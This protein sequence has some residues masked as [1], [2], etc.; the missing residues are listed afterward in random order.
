MAGGGVKGG[1]RW[2]DLTSRQ[3]DRRPAIAVAELFATF[4]RLLKIDGGKEFHAGLR[5]IH[6]IDPAGKVIPELLT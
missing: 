6:L 3:E 4:A 2:H 5:P 1:R